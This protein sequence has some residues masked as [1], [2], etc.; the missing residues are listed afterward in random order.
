[1]LSLREEEPE[2]DG[3]GKGPAEFRVDEVTLFE[4]DQKEVKRLSSM[5]LS[6]AV[7][8]LY[9]SALQK[10]DLVKLKELAS[11]DF[12]QRV[13]NRD[14]ARHFAIMPD[15]QIPD[16]EPQVISSSFRGDISE[17]T[18]SVGET[19]MTV[20]MH[21]AGG[22]MVVDDVLIPALDRPTSLKAN[23]EALLTVQ[24]FASAAHRGDLKELIRESA[25]GLDRLAW[26]QMTESPELLQQLVRPLVSE[27]VSI[28]PGD[29]WTLV[30]TSDGL[31]QAEIK[32]VRE[33]T[34]L[35]VHDVSLM[36]AAD[37]DQRMDLMGTLKQLIA[38]G[39]LGPGAKYQPEVMQ[40][41]GVES[42]PQQVQQ[43]V[44]EP[45]APE[46]YGK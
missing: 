11:A 18:I 41:S 1:M 45:L 26:R 23:L 6:H 9:V 39:Q 36:S 16:A 14:A 3:K 21:F 20:V 19:P 27:V 2:L 15:P 4:N 43:A 42:Q 33:G 7:A 31:V 12:Q 30:R 8:N 25:D 5:F 32:I 44:F 24:A 29:P 37:E 13:W 28:R 40:A 22:W 38:A 46:I 34:Q 17:V 35:V 10:R